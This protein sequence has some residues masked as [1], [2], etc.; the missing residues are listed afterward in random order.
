MSAKVLMIAALGEAGTGV[1]LLIAPALVVWLLLGQDLAVASVPVARVA[2]IALLA[3]GLACWPGPP[4]L[5][6]LA[7]STGVTLYIAW[8]G[9]A[10]AAAGLLL[11]PA[12]ALHLVLSALLLRAWL[13]TWARPYGPD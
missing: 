8:L 5:G 4:R 9:L 13:T 10:G 3:L 2:G 11:W 12:V 6:M 1:A 7:Y